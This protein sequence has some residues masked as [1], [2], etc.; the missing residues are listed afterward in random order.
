[1]ERDRATIRQTILP[2]GHRPTV[3]K[4]KTAPRGRSVPLDQHTLE[5]LRAH[6]KGQLGQ[7]LPVGP[8]Y[9]DHGL[10]FARADGDRAA[11]TNLAVAPGCHE[12]C[13]VRGPLRQHRASMG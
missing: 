1:M 3:G 8:A 12:A 6:R 11:S 9:Q 4:P 2:I 5:A 10:I 13:S 7:R